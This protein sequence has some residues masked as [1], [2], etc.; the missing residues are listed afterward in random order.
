MKKI[1]ATIIFLI[2]FLLILAIDLLFYKHI[3]IFLPTHEKE[4][5]SFEKDITSENRDF[6]LTMY[7]QVEKQSNYKMIYEKEL[8][9]IEKNEIIYNII[10]NSISNE[11]NDEQIKRLIIEYFYMDELPKT[12]YGDLKVING[13]CVYID[14]IGKEINF[15]ILYSNDMKKIYYIDK[16][17]VE[18]EFFRNIELKY[19]GEEDKDEL[20]ETEEK[21][22]YDKMSKTE[23]I[24]NCKE[25]LKEYIKNIEFEPETIMYK[26]IYYILKDTTKDITVYYNSNNNAI[27]GL[28]MGFEK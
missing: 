26:G 24:N 12:I 3:N 25:I 15:L 5:F 20:Q 7:E 10:K 9:N 8:S 11:M 19:G 14:E 16:N 18:L 23:L 22:Q 17:I 1:K 21:L 6:L 28:Y 13:Q 4:V 2:I 27:L